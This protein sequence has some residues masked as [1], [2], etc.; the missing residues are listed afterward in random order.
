LSEECLT[1]KSNSGEKRIS[2]GPSIHEGRF[3]F[4]EHAYPAAMKGWLVLVLKRHASALHEL[5]LEEW[6]ELAELQARTVKL[7]HAQFDTAKEYS[8]CLA[9]GPGFQHIH[10]HMVARASD[11]PAE[12]KGA[13]IFKMLKPD[14]QTV[15]PPAEIKTLC[16]NLAAKF[17]ALS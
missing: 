13:A 8:I 4:L 6:Q 12:L 10:F 11:L 1:C 2:P 9:E 7:L 16:E 15:V 3:W 5:T 14:E 17:N